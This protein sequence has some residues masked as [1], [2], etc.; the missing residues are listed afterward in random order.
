VLDIENENVTPEDIL[1]LATD[2][3]WDVVSN[4]D[5]ANIVQRGLSA[6]DNESRAGRPKI[7]KSNATNIRLQKCITAGCMSL[8]VL[9]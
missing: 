2:G 6:W 8:I 7:I 9:S 1:V 4:D 3:L 5:V